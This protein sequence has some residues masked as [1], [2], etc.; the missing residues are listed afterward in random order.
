MNMRFALFCVAI[1]LFA[2]TCMAQARIPK[3]YQDFSLSEIKSSNVSVKKVLYKGRQSFRLTMPSK[4]YQDP[5]KEA[6]TDRPNLAWVPLDFHNGTIECDLLA[7]LSDDAPSYARGFIGIGFR[8]DSKLNFEGLYLRPVNSRVDDQV[9][10]NH[11]VQYFSLPGYDFDRLRKESPERYESYADINLDEWIHLKIE[12]NQNIA[13][14]YVNNMK[15]PALIVSDL[16]LGPDQ[17]GGVGFWLESGT[18]GY[19]SNLSITMD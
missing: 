6:L 16:K 2:G 3:K 9:R 11:S 14:L 13:R 5:Q 7:V 17:R 10:R 4:L 19:F 8:I 12:V 18:I 1:M 15:Q